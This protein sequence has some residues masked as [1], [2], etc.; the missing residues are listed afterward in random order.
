L[1]E[2]RWNMCPYCATALT[3]PDESDMTTEGELA[4]PVALPDWVS[5]A[6][7]RLRAR[8]LGT[9]SEAGWLAGRPRH[10]ALPEGQRQPAAAPLDAADGATNGAHEPDLPEIRPPAPW[11]RRARHDAATMPPDGHTKPDETPVA[12]GSSSDTLP[13]SNVVER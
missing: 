7:Q 4:T 9:R 10:R 1:V 13:T 12:S 8:M 11:P 5:P 2:L 6:I 3:S